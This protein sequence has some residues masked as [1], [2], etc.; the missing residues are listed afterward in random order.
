MSW[1]P[2][3]M[4]MASDNML[5]VHNWGVVYLNLTKRLHDMDKPSLEEKK[6]LDVS[7]IY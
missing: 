4:L 2:L 6:T 7:S 3:R 1:D 5:Y